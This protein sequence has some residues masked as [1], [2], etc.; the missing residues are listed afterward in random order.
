MQRDLLRV[1]VAREE[2]RRKKIVGGIARLIYKYDET[3][4]ALSH[5]YR[6]IGFN[7]SFYINDLFN[8]AA[9]NFFL[10]SFACLF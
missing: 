1:T 8:I 3:F 4:A 6:Y 9:S 10:S 2:R 5:T 7:F